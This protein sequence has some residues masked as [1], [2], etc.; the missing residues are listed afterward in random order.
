VLSLTFNE[1]AMAAV[2]VMRKSKETVAAGSATA[3]MKVAD[4]SRQMATTDAAEV[5]AADM[6][7]VATE[8]ATAVMEAADASRQSQSEKLCDQLLKYQV[9]VYSCDRGR[10]SGVK[11]RLNDCGR[12]I[13]ESSSDVATTDA[14]EVTAADMEAVATESATAV[15]E[16][17]LSQ[18]NDCGRMIGES[19]SDGEYFLSRL[20]D[21]GRMIGES[22]I[23]APRS[24][25]EYIL[26]R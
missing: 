23:G 7:A 9:L 24:K 25:T 21:C 1:K 10:C 5:T 19:S 15:T 12:M 4:S 2:V 8:S 3:V 17:F 18:L 26:P 11:C 20:N 6:E 16:Y 22:S 13:G 14:A